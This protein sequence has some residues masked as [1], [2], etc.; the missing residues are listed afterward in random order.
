MLPRLMAAV[1]VLV[2]VCGCESEGTVAEPADSSRAVVDMSLG[3][4]KAHAAMVGMRGVQPYHANGPHARHLR[5][6]ALADNEGDVCAFSQL[7]FVAMEHAYPSVDDIMDRVLV[8]HQWMGE[9]FEQLLHTL[10]ADVRVLMGS[11]TAI[12]IADDIRPS[13]YWSLTGAIYLDGYHLWLTPEERSTF[14][15]LRISA[16]P[17]EK[18]SA[19]PFHAWWRYVKDDDFAYRMWGDWDATERDIE[20]AVL[21]IAA[22]LFHELAHANDYF[23]ADELRSIDRSWT[24]ARARA[25]LE[26][27]RASAAL[28][29]S[30]PLHSEVMF[31]VAAAI[32]RQA[33]LTGS[34]AKMV[35][36][37]VGLAFQM[38]LAN[39]DYAYISRFEDV[40]MLF[41]E[42]M[43]LRHYRVQRDVAYL[44]PAAVPE[45]AQ[46]D[47]FLVGWGT[48][49]RIADVE[50]RPRAQ[51]VAEAIMPSRQWPSFFAALP[52][53]Q[54][55]PFG[56]GWCQSLLVGDD[57]A[58]A[59]SPTHQ[60]LSAGGFTQQRLYKAQR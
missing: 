17:N 53:P 45:N 29:H 60:S 54:F 20:Q 28:Y 59:A 36:E 30:A 9:R 56:K 50:V 37:D 38:G 22:T 21:P 31:R 5:E 39:D 58:A 16:I 6:C 48:R 32:H 25:E 44:H 14:S 47:D 26:P 7:P 13:Y 15:S 24:V 57:Q 43:M 52:A 46:C 2:I 55:L 33:P 40:A 41:E 18:H 8:S 11:V 51:L 27:V 19:L 1:I 34:D 23:P 3:G 10:P 49:N 35:A 4:E 12:V 42:T